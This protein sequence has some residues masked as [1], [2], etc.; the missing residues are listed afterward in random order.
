LWPAARISLPY[1]APQYMERQYM[2]RQLARTTRQQP[3]IYQL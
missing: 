2:A 3:Q 1:M